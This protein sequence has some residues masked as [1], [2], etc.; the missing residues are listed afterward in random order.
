M[1]LGGTPT[2][3]WIGKAR[4]H[5]HARIVVVGKASLEDLDSK[6]GTFLAGKRLGKKTALADGDEVRIGP[7]DDGVPGHELRNDE[8]GEAK[9]TT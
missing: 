8:D 7:R 2:A 4:I 1:S 5:R 9:L 3:R 6:N